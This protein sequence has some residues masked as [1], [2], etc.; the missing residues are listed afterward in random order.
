MS[1]ASLSEA[2]LEGAHRKQAKHLDNPSVSCKAARSGFWLSQMGIQLPSTAV[3]LG[4]IC[5]VWE[6]WLPDMR[7]APLPPHCM[8]LAK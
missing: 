2:P 3:V 7:L 8:R 1:M 4:W 6:G 5:W